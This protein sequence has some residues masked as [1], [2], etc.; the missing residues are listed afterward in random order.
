MNKKI[1]KPI[2]QDSGITVIMLIITIIIIIIIS[3]VV[4]SA[5]TG[6]DGIINMAI[7]SSTRYKRTENKEYNKLLQAQAD[8][9]VG[10]STLENQ[11]INYVESTARLMNPDRGFYYPCNINGTS[12]GFNYA[13]IN[14]A[15]GQAKAENKTL[16]HL[17]IDISKLSGRANG[18]K[19]LNLSKADKE[20]LNSVFDLLRTNKL[21][22]IVRIAYDFDGVENKEPDKIETI[23][24]HIEQFKEVFE[25][26]K[27]VITV[28]ETGFIGIWGEMH[29]SK[30]ANPNDTSKVIKAL[31][32]SVPDTITVNAR[33]LDMYRNIYGS[34]PITES[35]AYDGSD[36]SRLGMFN[37]GY[38]GDETDLGSY[39]NRE[40]DLKFLE[41]HAKYTIFG[42]EAVAP[43]NKYNDIEN[44]QKEM[45]RT[46]TTYLNYMWNTAI[47]QDKWGNTTYNGDNEVYKGKTAQKY[48]EDHLGYRFVLKKSRMSKDVKQG[49]K[50]AISINIENTGFGNVVNDKKVQ[51]ILKSNT[52]AYKVDTNV[53]VREWD[54]NKTTTK[55][56]V[57]TIPGDIVEGEWEV[58]L[59]IADYDNEQ[60]VIQFAND[61]IFDQNLNANY[62]GM[63][64]VV[65]NENA[66]NVGLKQEYAEFEGG[67][68][69]ETVASEYKIKLDG[70]ITN[71]SE[72]KDEN[73]LYQSNDDKQ[74]KLYVMTDEKY[75]YLY[76]QDQYTTSK[77][78]PLAIHI[79]FATKDSVQKDDY[80]YSIENEHLYRGNLFVSDYE[81]IGTVKMKKTD[82]YEYII[83]LKD[84]GIQEYEDLSYIWVRMLDATTSSWTEIY[85]YTGTIK[86]KGEI[87]ITVDGN[88]DEWTQ[89]QLVAEKDG[90]KVYYCEKEN[91]GYL[92]CSPVDK[93]VYQN[94]LV[95][96]GV[97]G[98]CYSIAYSSGRWNGTWSAND[99]SKDELYPW[100]G[101][102]TLKENVAESFSEQGDNGIEYQ[103]RLNAL[104]T[105]KD[106]T[107][108]KLELFKG[109][110]G[111]W[112]NFTIEFERKK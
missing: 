44:A 55:N 54:S 45:F 28:V 82:G 15:I 14:N 83:P 12:T 107:K 24:K 46:H 8:A 29:T 98:E 30:Y 74:S 109:G 63:F 11:N 64:N 67:S 56:M 62:I 76:I 40:V 78:I 81:H 22:A 50:L 13:Q 85:N 60:Y 72:W 41:S 39:K 112:P 106:Y 108:I 35:I 27:D 47:T 77:K 68:N 73:I 48:I 5:I 26:N 7:S 16:I 71:A 95:K 87:A 58:Y 91:Y 17:R 4:V 79:K 61:G 49:E 96:Y 57:F 32:K 104:D 88:G 37:D 92:Y 19:D 97:Q 33:T 20:D 99:V 10:L 102:A 103:M 23:L 105:T 70:K 51:L 52:D 84:I 43:D 75:L 31:L 94:A 100:A 110:Y 25:K 34:H 66:P 86:K 9:Y 89:E 111:G 6:E 80:K 69:K 90:I 42:G 53:D 59:K 18:N 36:Q 2:K 3:V 101:N 65:K 1:N 21:K 38:L 93:S